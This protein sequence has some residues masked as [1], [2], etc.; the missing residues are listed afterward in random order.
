MS[1]QPEF[2]A[3]KL[4][5]IDNDLGSV[6]HDMAE[7]QN[8]KKALLAMREAL[9]KLLPTGSVPPFVTAKSAAASVSANSPVNT[10]FRNAV[11]LA[12]KEHPKGLKPAQLIQLL[13]QR[14]DLA[15]YSGKVRPKDRVYNELYSLKQSKEVSKRYGR[16]VYIHS[17]GSN[18]Q[19]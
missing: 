19:A 1:Q 8:K 13:D 3:I 9:L 12:L 15:K 2:A 17:E 10:G 4:A 7:L 5:E 18:G 6:D 11:R 14:G 16:Y